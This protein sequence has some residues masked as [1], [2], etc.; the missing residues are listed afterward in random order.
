M[1]AIGLN[2]LGTQVADVSDSALQ[3]LG[4]GGGPPL[5]LSG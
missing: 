5:D 1:Q 3:P 4:G 2:F